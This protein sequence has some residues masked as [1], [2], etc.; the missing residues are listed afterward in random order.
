MLAE[1]SCGPFGVEALEYLLERL[2]GNAG[3]GIL[4]HD[5]HTV[6]ALA[7]PDAHRVA[8]LAERDRVGDE[9]DE[10]LGQAAFESGDDDRFGRQVRDEIDALRFRVLTEVFGQVAE[11][12]H[13]VEALLLF[14]DQFAVEPRRIG[15]VADQAVEAAHVMVDDIEELGAL[16]LLL[17]H[18]QR[19]DGGA[20]RGKRVLDLVRHI[21]GELFVR[22]DPL[23]KRR[24]HPPHR[25]RKPPD[26][27]GTRGQVRNADAA[28]AHLPG[29]LVAAEFRRRGEVRKRIGDGR[30]ED[31]AEADRDD[32]GDDEHLEHLLA[33]HPDKLV[34]LAR[35]RGDGGDAHDLG[36]LPDR[37]GDGEDRLSGGV[38]PGPHLGLALQR[39]GDELARHVFGGQARI[40]GVLRR[41]QA[42]D[43]FPD[44]GEDVGDEGRAV[45]A[46]KPLDRF[47]RRTVHAHGRYDQGLGRVE[48][49]KLRALGQFDPHRGPDRVDPV[50]GGEV[51]RPPVLR[52]QRLEH[53]G[54][55]LGLG[56]QAA[57]ALEHKA[58]A[59]RIEI[60]HARDEHDHRQEVEGDDLAGKGRAVERDEVAPLAPGLQLGI[61]HTFGSRPILTEDDVRTPVPRLSAQVYS[62]GQGH[63]SL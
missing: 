24:D 8:I 20:Q 5:Q 44:L 63:S 51:D 6:L 19:T 40:G 38:M 34:D 37:G 45:I 49:E 60:E 11:H 42:C 62:C 52:Q 50:A 26:L 27:I 7:R 54:D 12:L 32:D 22:L 18:A 17:D 39:A 58:V 10:D 46:L 1:L 3:A 33:L 9:I 59:E 53:V 56:H 23:V 28:R 25:A 61:D 36:A 43:G 47:G 4:D 41:E 14:L 48:D 30:R 15:N 31:E 16:L 13:E 57:F 29:I 55:E 35:D 21:G 2:V